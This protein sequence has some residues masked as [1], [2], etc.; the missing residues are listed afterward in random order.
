MPI[1]Y[2]GVRFVD[3]TINLKGEKEKVHRE[4]K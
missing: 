4:V 2:S 1:D 3:A